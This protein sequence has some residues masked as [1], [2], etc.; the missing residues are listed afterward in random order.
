MSGVFVCLKFENKETI[1]EDRLWCIVNYLL[2]IVSLSKSNSLVDQ[3]PFLFEKSQ[4]AK[5]L[6][7]TN[8]PENDAQ[9][10]SIMHYMISVETNVNCHWSNK[11]IPWRHRPVGEKERQKERKRESPCP[12]FQHICPCFIVIAASLSLAL[13]PLQWMC[14]M[15]MNVVNMFSR[16]PWL[17]HCKD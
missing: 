3:G 13:T 6:T 11:Q 10:Q 5:L 8:H 17:W 16:I 15:C 1:T 14:E 9:F 7:A 4:A 2:R 12:V